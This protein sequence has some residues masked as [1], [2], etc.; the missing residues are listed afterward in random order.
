MYQPTLSYFLSLSVQTRYTW[1]VLRKE[2]MRT[3]STESAIQGAL[4]QKPSRGISF[5][6]AAQ[7]RISKSTLHLFS[8]KINLTDLTACTLKRSHRNRQV[9]NPQQKAELIEYLINAQKLNHGLTQIDTRKSAYSYGKANNITI[10]S[11]CTTNKAAGCDWF[12][13]FLKRSHK[14][15]IKKPRTNKSGQSSCCKSLCYW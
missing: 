8:K 9:F 10:P 13:L 1:H 11:Q 15:T 14:L 6:K 12:T 4:Y 2:R 7:G 3:A 5:R